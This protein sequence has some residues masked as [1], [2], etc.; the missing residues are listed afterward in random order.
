MITEI[1]ISKGTKRNVLYIFDIAFKYYCKK[2]KKLSKVLRSVYS[3]EHKNLCNRF[4][5]DTVTKS[6]IVI[7]FDS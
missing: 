2:C 5:N 6:T 4:E 3:E 1:H 7:L